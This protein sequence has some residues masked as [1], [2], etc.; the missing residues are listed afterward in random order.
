MLTLR[1]KEMKCRVIYKI[2]GSE[3]DMNRELKLASK[4]FDGVVGEYSPESNSYCVYIGGLFDNEEDCRK[5]IYEQKRK[6]PSLNIFLQTKER[7]Q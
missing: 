6:K 5:Y 3:K 2:L 7:W 1:E 4:L